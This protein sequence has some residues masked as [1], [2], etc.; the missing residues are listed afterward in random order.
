MWGQA[1]AAC[2]NLDQSLAMSCGDWIDVGMLSINVVVLLVLAVTLCFAA[3]SYCRQARSSDYSS[4][5]DLLTRFSTAWRRFRDI[6]EES[7][8]K[9]Y[10][11]CE[12]LSL[13]EISCL[14][15]RCGTIKGAFKGMLRSKLKEYISKISANEYALRHL[16][17][18]KSGPETF[19]EIQLFAKRHGI[20]F[21]DG[22][23]G[24]R[25]SADLP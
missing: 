11:F 1:V 5:L 2:T 23:F 20:E 17:E 14:L 9:S 6:S 22:T 7:E 19:K 18:N 3:L 24:P 12:L 10:E 16:R 21:P 8:E 25:P 13:M 4:Y 15:W